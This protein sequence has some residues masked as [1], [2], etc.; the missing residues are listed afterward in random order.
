MSWRTHTLTLFA[1]HIGRKLGINRWLASWVNDSGYETRYDN[2]FCSLIRR[3]DCVW[4]VGAN[5]GYY[6]QL[7]SERVS[8]GS[9]FT[10]SA[11]VAALLFV[12]PHMAAIAVAA[13]GLASLVSAIG[14]LQRGTQLKS[15]VLRIAALV[16]LVGV[17][18]VVFSQTSQFFGE[19]TPGDG[20][21]TGVEGVLESTKA[22]TSIGG[23]E[24]EAPSVSSPA[25]LPWATVTVLFRPF[26]WEASS[27][28]GLIAALEG[29]GLLILLVASWRRIATGFVLML[30]RPYLVFV[31]VFAFV[32]ITAFSYVGNFGIL[33]RQRTQLLPLVLVFIALPPLAKRRGLFTSSAN[34]PLDVVE[35]VDHSDRDHR[36]RDVRDTSA[37]V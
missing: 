9:V 29:F 19:E 12:R 5:V 35:E 17:A 6:T 33:T 14:G 11:G 27:G 22:Q 13:L 36:P 28:S 24:F 18:V 31:A 25:D 7:F 8:V 16:L 23:S 32:F 15:T 3:G 34:R 30:R 1:R 37:V 10:F 26:P 20:G 2:G 21:A 4:D